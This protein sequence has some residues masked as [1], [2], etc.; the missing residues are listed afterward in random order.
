MTGDQM[1]NIMVSVLWKYQAYLWHLSIK[2]DR[3]WSQESWRKYELMHFASQWQLPHWFLPC[4]YPGHPGCLEQVFECHSGGTSP[5]TQAWLL[6]LTFSPLFHKIYFTKDLWWQL[7]WSYKNSAADPFLGEIY[8]W[9][10]P[11]IKWLLHARYHG[12]KAQFQSILFF[13]C[14]YFTWL[15]TKS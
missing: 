5:D 11:G 4:A 14:Y 9:S 1:V 8:L 3:V 6:W 13:L 15:C 2:S 7:K 10:H 12:M